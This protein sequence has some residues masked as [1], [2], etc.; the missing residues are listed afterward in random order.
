MECVEDVV[1]ILTLFYN[2]MPSLYNLPHQR[3]ELSPPVQLK[4]EITNKHSVM[5]TLVNWVLDLRLRVNLYLQ[6]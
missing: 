4:D 3:L 1:A 2:K 6:L 5:I